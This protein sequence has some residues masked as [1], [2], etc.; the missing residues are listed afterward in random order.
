MKVSK[1]QSSANRQAILETA[2]RLY[3][4]RGIGGVG[5]AEITREAG[6]THGGFYGHFDSKEALAAEACE[7]AFAAPLARLNATLEKHEGDATPYITN[8]LR[9]QHRDKPGEGCPMPTLAIDAGREPGL[10][11]DA[12]TQGISGYLKAFASHR[13]DGS[14]TEAPEAADKA[15]AVVVLSALIG[16][17]VLARATS[18]AA[19]ALSDEILAILQEELSTFWKNG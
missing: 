6:F 19:P 17:M 3:R 18:S 11:S 12:V 10:V 1:E 4:E 8:Y 16:G 2:A 5:V 13:P 9:T 7:L 14:V 15:R